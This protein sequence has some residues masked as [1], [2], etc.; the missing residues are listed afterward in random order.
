MFSDI[1]ADLFILADG[2]GSC[3]PSDAPALISRLIETS[4]DMVVGTRDDGAEAAIPS[5]LA[6]GLFG[7]SVGPIFSGYR[8]LTKRFV[9]SLPILDTGLDVEAQMFA[10]AHVLQVPTSDLMLVDKAPHESSSRV[11]KRSLAQFKVLK[12]LVRL[13]AGTLPSSFSR[14]TAKILGIACLGLVA[15]PL[16]ASV[17]N[18][19]PALEPTLLLIGNLFLA[20]FI[21]GTCC[22]LLNASHTSACIEQRRLAY[23]SYPV[24]C[25]TK[26]IE[27]Q[28]CIEPGTR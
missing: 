4:S 27:R 9:K 23:M 10:H 7:T 28:D 19:A 2:D 8:V 18:D 11:P 12:T 5:R 16:F 21:L 22:I 24:F 17:L 20:M 3:D 6:R 14:I 13:A 26:D 1:D 15:L 25:D